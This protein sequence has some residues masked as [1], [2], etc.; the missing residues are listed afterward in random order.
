[1]TTLAAGWGIAHSDFQ[2]VLKGP[3]KLIWHYLTNKFDL[4]VYRQEHK[5]VF[6]N[7][8]LKQIYLFHSVDWNYKNKIGF[9]VCK[10]GNGKLNR[11]CEK[12][13]LTSPTPHHTLRSAR[14]IR[15][16]S[17]WCFCNSLNHF[18]RRDLKFEAA[19]VLNT[20]LKYV[21]H[22]YLLWKKKIV[23]SNR[24]LSFDIYFPA[25]AANAMWNE[26][27]SRWKGSFRKS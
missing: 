20:P 8:V 19:C 12:S 17:F 15:E 26:S 4:S 13:A 11:K 7:I 22:K 25:P 24:N 23:H 16:S 14:F 6:I 18:P 9:P 10:K 5:K 27:V 21:D 2:I 1:M 3:S